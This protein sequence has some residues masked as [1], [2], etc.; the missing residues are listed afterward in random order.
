MSRSD[1]FHAG[2]LTKPLTSIVFMALM[3]V[4]LPA[5]KTVHRD[6]ARESVGGGAAAEDVAAGIPVPASTPFDGMT[7]ARSLY[8]QS[9]QEG[10]RSGFPGFTAPPWTWV[11]GMYDRAEP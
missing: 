1:C 3:L 4:A 8:L 7:V 6:V 11:G 2:G 9:Y 10:Y 5:C